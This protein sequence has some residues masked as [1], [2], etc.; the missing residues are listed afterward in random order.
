MASGDTLSAFTPLHN[1]P[2][3]ANFA[4]LGTITGATGAR[5]FLLFDDTT[6][7]T[8]IFSGVMPRNY[9]GG[10]VTLT[11]WYAMDGANSSKAIVW[12]AAFE[13]IVD[14]DAMGSGGNDFAAVN[15]VTDTVDDT[16]DN[17]DPATITFTDGAD[18]DSV[19]AGDPFRLKITRDADN[20][21]DTSVNDA[22][23][24]YVE[25]KET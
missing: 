3:A 7:E 21:S 10:G 14:G 8:A 5:T 22:Q 16:A 18:M 19:V 9:D 20:G 15:S 24:L 13:R 17:I 12:D 2:P 6:D 11:L 23:L 25:V 4:T 1:E